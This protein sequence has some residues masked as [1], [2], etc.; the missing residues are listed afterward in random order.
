MKKNVF[1]AAAC[2]VL[3]I[4]ILTG[5]QSRALKPEGLSDGVTVLDPYQY[6]PLAWSPLYPEGSLKLSREKMTVPDDSVVRNI[7]FFER[8]GKSVIEAV[9]DTDI[10]FYGSGEVDG[11]LRRNGTEVMFWNTDNFVYEW[12][13]MPL[14]QSHPWI[15]GVRKDG[16]AFGLIIDSTWRGILNLKTPGKVIFEFEGP[17]PR[18]ICLEGD[19]PIDVVKKL[20]EVTGKMELPPLWS[21]GYQQSRWSYET[22]EKAIT[23]AKTFRDKK[24]PCDVIWFDIDYMDGFRIFT[25]NPKTFADPKKLNDELHA[26]NF[27]SI[28]MID[29][30]FKDDPNSP[31]LKDGIEKDVFVKTADGKTDFIGNVWPG[32]CRFPDFT[33]PETRQWWSGLYKDFM[34]TGADGIWNDMNEPAVMNGKNKTMPDSNLH[35]GG[36]E[37]LPGPHNQYHNI[38]ALLMLKA[39]REGMMAARP[40]ERPFLLTRANFLGG[41][42][43][44]AT[45]TGDN[46]SS[47]DQMEL[48]IPMSLT[49]SLSAQPF[50]GPDVPGFAG[51]PSPEL[52]R[53]WFALAPFY[54]FARGHACK[55]TVNKEPWSFGPAVEE[56]AR[57]ALN[58]RYKL[59]PYLYTQFYE[60]SRTGV[61]V[62]RPLFFLDPKNPAYRTEQESFMF[63]PDLIVTPSWASRK[64][65]L[66]GWPVVSLVEGDLK[67]SYQMEVRARP[68]AIIPLCGNDPQSTEEVDFDNLEALIIYDEKDEKASGSVYVDDGKTFKY[69]TGKYRHITR[70]VDFEDG[71]IEGRGANIQGQY[72][73]GKF[74]TERI[75]KR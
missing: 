75:I 48:S 74:R 33:R 15:M 34:A 41:Q 32:P 20:S 7:H 37:L 72:S 64:D 2:G 3:T 63:G 55:G 16:T 12:K 47:R 43:Y 67:D 21:L 73:K 66:P 5:C 56:T 27:K 8:N 25:F 59:M 26:L 50:N 52:A 38:Y 46:K 49:L 31:F 9:V 65:H 71:K 62:M 35:R 51:N 4:A 44:S 53:D 22:P 69:K 68:G 36:G 24:I 14:Y 39:S 17:M 18:C 29:P 54:P 61:P 28:W 45:W 57:I 40:H 6:K 10:D 13:Q 30:A 23:I 1:L 42:R 19:S 70:S 58:R 60:A 11:N